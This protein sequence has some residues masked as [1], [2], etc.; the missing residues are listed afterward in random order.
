MI[1]AIV[2]FFLG[3]FFCAAAAFG[4]Y[5]LTIIKR[6]TAMVELQV[7]ATNELLGEGSFTR[8]S[9]SLSAL[10]NAMPDMLG[11]IKEFASVMRLV[12]KANEETDNPKRVPPVD[13]GSGFY[14]H[15]DQQAAINEVDA[16]ARRQKIII[17]PEELAKFHTDE[18]T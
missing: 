2:A 17:P 14:T 7:K 12:F 18:A 1:Y 4:W 9:K 6:L 5:L 3:I 10:N 8:I 15:S 16:E 13:P 11:G